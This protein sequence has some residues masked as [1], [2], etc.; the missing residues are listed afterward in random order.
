MPVDP[1]SCEC[2]AEVDRHAE[3]SKHELV[4][5]GAVK[6]PHKASLHRAPPVA[7]CILYLLTEQRGGVAA[8]GRLSKSACDS[9][10]DKRRFVCPT[11]TRTC[12]AAAVVWRAQTWF[13]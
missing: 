5:Q 12:A 7:H 11:A 1:V 8:V 2:G 9:R 13:V 6:A 4:G 3:L 10:A